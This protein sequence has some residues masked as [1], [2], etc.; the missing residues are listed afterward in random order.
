M[1]V[2]SVHL[3]SARDGSVT[4]LARAHICNVGG[5]DRLG[6]YEVKTLRG[7]GTRALNSRVVQRAGKVLQH[8]RMQLHVWHLV[9]KALSAVGYGRS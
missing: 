8:A 5:T 4:E 1:I 6:D 3:V 7:R 2:V 9:A